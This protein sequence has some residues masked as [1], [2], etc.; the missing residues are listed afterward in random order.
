MFDKFYN[1]I[2]KQ[3]AHITIQESKV[4]DN[5]I[6][7]GSPVDS[8]WYILWN[9]KKTEIKDDKI[10]V[11]MYNN[12]E[13]AWQV[14][15]GFRSSPVNW[16]KSNGQFITRWVGARVYTRAYDENHIQVLN[17]IKKKIW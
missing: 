15:Y 6:W 3:I 14:E 10:V 4:I 2:Q 12:S 5:D 17:N 13:N 11:D 8:G 1:T 9:R 16:S 7:L